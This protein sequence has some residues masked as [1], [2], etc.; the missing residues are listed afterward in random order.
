MKK[1]LVIGGFGNIGSSV[2][3]R[4]MTEGFDVTVMSSGKGKPAPYFEGEILYADR[5]NRN[6]FLQAVK[7]KKYEYVVDLVCHSA[8]DA[9]LAYEAFPELEHLV[10]TSSGAVYGKLHAGEIPVRETMKREPV[11]SYGVNKK[12]MEDFFFEKIMKEN[13]PVTIFRPTVTYGRQREIVRQ[14]ASDNSW[15]DRIRKGKAIVTGNPFILRNFL[16]VDDAATAFWG[17][18]QHECCKGQVYNLC[19]TKPY[20]WE[21]YHRT[22]M[23]VL[24]REV[25]MIEIPY[26]FLCKS[27][28][29]HV[30]EMIQYNF[31]YNGYYSSDKITKDIPEFCVKKDLK[32]G[33]ESA[34]Q[35][36]EEYG[37]I[38]DSDELMWE[39]LLIEE[40]RK[41]GRL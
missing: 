3:E 17:A 41:S 2:T 13:Y 33:L 9:E 25:D 36:I 11:W 24:G 8:A 39:D 20:D 26:D 35:W 30:T 1:T 19:G 28:F 23:Q 37:V 6:S 18:F 21:T 32:S 27:A 7:N 10:V 15:I 12:A 34:V 29:F 40:Y 5:H 14:I 4:L 38:P 31:I 22:V 16:H